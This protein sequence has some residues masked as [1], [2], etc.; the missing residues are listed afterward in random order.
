MLAPLTTPF[1]KSRTCR[2]VL[3]A[4]LGRLGQGKAGSRRSRAQ[5]RAQQEE[6]V[7]ALKVVLTATIVAIN[8]IA[9]LPNFRRKY[10]A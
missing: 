8:L 1:G 2:G 3:F 7:D 5:S 10:L 6:P 4:V 9:D